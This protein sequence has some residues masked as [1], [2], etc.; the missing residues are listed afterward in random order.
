MMPQDFL[1][2]AISHETIQ[3]GFISIFLCKE[4]IT[5][6]FLREMSGKSCGLNTQHLKREEGKSHKKLQPTEH[7]LPTG[8]MDG[9]FPSSSQLTEKD[10][11]VHS[12][13]FTPLV[14]P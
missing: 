6:L 13:T 11:P 14:P 4:K 3:H 7:S 2:V 10:C 9:M 1:K 5:T 8:E 12:C